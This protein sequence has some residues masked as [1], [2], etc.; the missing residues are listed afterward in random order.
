MLGR[1][2]LA[3]I[4]SRIVFITLQRAF[5][6][7]TLRAGTGHTSARTPLGL[8]ARNRLYVEDFA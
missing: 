7:L 1:D 4:K 5:S 6:F 8:D 2:V 3:F